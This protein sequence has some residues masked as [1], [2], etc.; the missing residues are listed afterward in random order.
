[1]TWVVDSMGLCYEKTQQLVL[2]FIVQA[3][4]N[5]G[6]VLMD[7]KFLQDTLSKKA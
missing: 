4:R 1:M 7:S 3:V 5:N 6:W 2:L